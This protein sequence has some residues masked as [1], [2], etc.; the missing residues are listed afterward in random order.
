MND[1][2]ELTHG[3]VVGFFRRGFLFALL[4]SV[5]LGA[6]LYYWSSR[7]GPSF[8]AEAVLVAKSPQVDL[9]TLGLP[10]IND[11]PL[12]VDAYSVAATSTPVLTA[13]LQS[14]G[15]PV[16]QGAVDAL[17]GD[18]LQIRVVPDPQLVYLTVTADAPGK[19]ANLAN[20]VAEQ[21]QLWDRSRIT[22]ELQRVA[23]I[24]TQRIAAQQVLLEQLADQ[25]SRDT[26]IQLA[27]ERQVL[28]DLDGQLDSI[29][30][31][32]SNTTSTLKVLRAATPADKSIGRSPMMFGLLGI[33]VG[34]LV[35]YALMFVV[36]LFDGRLYTS[37]SVERAADLPIL[38]A[39]T[40]QKPG[41]TTTAEAAMMLYSNLA[42]AMDLNRQTTIL[43]TGVGYN[44]DTATTAMVL[45][46]SFA[47]RGTNTLLVDAD[48]QQPAIARRYRVP[49]INNLSLMS[50]VRGRQG[51]RQPLRLKI[52]ERAQFSLIYE[53][54]PA[55]N[56][57]QAMLNGLAGCLERWREEFDA[58][59]I[60]TTP[61]SL[62]G[63]AF[64]LGWSCDGVVLAVNPRTTNRQRLMSTIARLRRAGAPL[65]A[66]VTT[67]MRGPK[68]PRW[69]RVSSVDAEVMPSAPRAKA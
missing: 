50:C 56:E 9:R 61:V 41:R 59:I 13:A 30:A 7:A 64:I 29:V 11:M 31:L 49:G 52:G 17:R 10:E 18:Q 27:S 8:R 69:Q 62:G 3:Q 28:T 20:A 54:K 46:E 55:P 63:D 37:E 15:S 42:T 34:L 60:R 36:E 35:A 51:P 25:P 45:A 53:S 66:G 67:G 58:I 47:R 19:A 23:T 44:D 21:L 14:L 5:L 32:T 2:V 12:H 24:L 68:G 39:L 43:V 40:R 65:V 57:T 22:D 33:I 48:L 6:G 26:A 16:T 1:G 4:V 38:A